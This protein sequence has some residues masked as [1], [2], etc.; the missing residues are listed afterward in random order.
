MLT[1]SF[2]FTVG[3]VW[4]NIRKLKVADCKY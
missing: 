1:F 3:R 2:I 4:V